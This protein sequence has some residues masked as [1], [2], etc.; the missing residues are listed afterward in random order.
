MCALTGSKI[1]S[2]RQ[3]SMQPRFFCFLFLPS[4]K[5]VWWCFN[6]NRPFFGPAGAL[7]KLFSLTVQRSC[8]IWVKCVRISSTWL[9]S[10]T[11]LGS[12]S[13]PEGLINFSEVFCIA[14]FEFLVEISQ[15]MVFRLIRGKNRGKCT[16]LRFLQY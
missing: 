11:E 1:V 13:D 2:I 7:C 6:I 5:V 12:C 14:D 15:K 16:F 4:Y 9:H 10:A 3:K 8:A